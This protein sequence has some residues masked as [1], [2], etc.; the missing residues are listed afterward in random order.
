SLKFFALFAFIPLVLLYEKKIWKIIA[1]GLSGISLT[2]VFSMIFS[3][4]LAFKAS[5]KFTLDMLKLFTNQAIPLS[6]GASSLFLVLIA[7]LFIYGYYREVKSDEELNRLSVYLVFVSYAIFFAFTKSYPY[8][9]VLI[10]PFMA[11]LI[12]LNLDKFRINR[13]L[14]IAFSVSAIASQ[15]IVYY[16]CFGIKTIQPMLLPKLFGEVASLPHVIST[17]AMVSH[18]SLY[19]LLTSLLLPMLIAVFVASLIALAVINFPRSPLSNEKELVEPSI[20]LHRLFI[21]ALLCSLPIL[22]Y[23]VSVIIKA[24]SI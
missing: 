17:E 14:E 23:L 2:V 18:T 3:G 12:F 1:Y 10:T 13:I 11:L 8:W 7:L 4:D 20:F 15:M 21:Y 5:G 24:V 9:L 6:I 16:W 22:G 19:T